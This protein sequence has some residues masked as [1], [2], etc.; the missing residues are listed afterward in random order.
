MTDTLTVIGVIGTEPRSVDTTSGTAMTT[1]R[2]ASAQRRYDRSTQRWVDG[3]TNWYTV[4]AFNGLAGNAL[5]SLARGDRV[6]VT[7]RL[8]VRSWESGGKAGTDVSVIAEGLGHDLAWGT[9]RCTRTVGRAKAAA[10]ESAAPE[11]A[12]AEAAAPE[13]VATRASGW[14]AEAPAAVEGASSASSAGDWGAA[15]AC[16]PEPSEASL[17]SVDAPF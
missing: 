10:P 13:A 3:A 15:R 2:L 11:S 14:S 8:S 12:T 6:L 5:A 16:A 4:N 9:T 1:F 7:G 17:E